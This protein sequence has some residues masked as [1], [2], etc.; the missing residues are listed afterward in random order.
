MEDTEKLRETIICMRREIDSLRTENLHSQLLLSALDAVL[1]TS[2][3]GDL[4]SGVFAAVKPVFE[5]SLALVLLELHPG[6]DA[7]QCVA[8]SRP[9]LMHHS[10]PVG[11]FLHKV[12]AGRTVSGVA[13]P[14]LDA[15]PQGP[16][17]T[18]SAQ[19]P[20]LYLPLL[21]QGRRSLMV[22]VREPHQSGFDRSHVALARKFSLLGT[23]V[24]AAQRATLKEAESRRLRE[25]QGKLQTSRD[26][27]RFRAN[28]DQ[29]TGLPNRAHV[30]ELVTALIARKPPGGKLAL[31]FINL[32]DFK[33]VNDLHGHAAGDALLREVT[34]RVQSQIR[35]A[36]VFGRINGDEF[37]IALDPVG[38]SSDVA[39]VIE[40]IRARLQQP[41][42]LHGTQIQPSASIGV[43]MFPAHGGDYETLRRNADLAMNRAKAAGKGGLDFFT[44]DLGREAQERLS[45]EQ[46]LRDAVSAGEFCCALQRKVDI[47]SGATTG[48]EALARWVDAEGVMRMPGQFLPLASRLQLLD[49]IALQVVDD[50]TRNLPQL[51]AMFGTAIKYS[52]NVSPAQAIDT[53]FMRRLTQRLPSGQAQRFI[54][55]LTEESLA[56]TGLLEAHVLPMLRQ[57]GVHVSIDD[58]GTGYSSLSKLASLT[59][60]ELKIDRSLVQTIQQLP[61]N[62]LILRAIES[63]GTALGLSIV[64]EGIET[65][66]ERDFLLANTAITMGQGFL[67]HKPQLIATLVGETP[68][69]P[70]PAPD[71]LESA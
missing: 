50:L 44:P 3:E 58:F 18:L 4:F 68:S 29:L 46:R 25:L 19:Q 62:Q 1:C 35:Q 71:R 43:A 60:D 69:M 12:L 56:D 20:A 42:T 52:I 48:F 10:W 38:Q 11:P 28:H 54:V 41:L 2:S 23:H 24:M 37:V 65:E 51:D 53:D 40:R 66:Q 6:S 34:A 17:G 61:R 30:Q 59:V 31:A 13:D 9:E 47:R 49:D 16:S 63:L 27:L 5:C 70:S 8:T 7:V 64:A 36:D 67:F 39:Q 15:W 21:I 45:L 57:A 22:L 55:E 32:D 33:R 26:A 14:L